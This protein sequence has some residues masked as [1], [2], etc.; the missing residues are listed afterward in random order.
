MKRARLTW[1]MHAT[2]PGPPASQLPRS[3]HMITIIKDP[4][5]ITLTTDEQLWITRE[6]EP[7]THPVI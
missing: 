4:V 7:G 5:T 3:Y 2:I 6:Y 1:A